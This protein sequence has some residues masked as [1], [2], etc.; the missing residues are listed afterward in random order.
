MNDWLEGRFLLDPHLPGIGDPGFLELEGNPVVDVVTDVL[1]VGQD[2]LNGGAGPFASQVGFHLHGVQATGDLGCRYAVIDKPLVD[3]IDGAN[4]I[5]RARHQDHAVC[6][7]TLVLAARK[8]A[9]HGSVLIDQDAAQAIA[10]RAALAIAEF[11]QS[12]LASE[13]LGR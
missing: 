4:F 3:Q 8:L 7:Q 2:F 13:Y 11:D 1:L 10:G 5:V 9:F 6:L 12:A